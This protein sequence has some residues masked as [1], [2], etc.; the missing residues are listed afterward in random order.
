MRI[1]RNAHK[2]VRYWNCDSSAGMSPLK[3][4]PWRS[5]LLR[6]HNIKTQSFTPLNLLLSFSCSRGTH[7]IWQRTKPWGFWK[8]NQYIRVI[9]QFNLSFGWE[10]VDLH[11]KFSMFCK[12]CGMLGDGEEVWT[13]NF[14]YRSIGD[15]IHFGTSWDANMS[16]ALHE[17]I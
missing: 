7:W 8:P 14:L 13:K 17:A 2:Y 1:A 3:P 10:L 12:C 4:L 16:L 5:L 15:Q 9:C 6:Q 11:P